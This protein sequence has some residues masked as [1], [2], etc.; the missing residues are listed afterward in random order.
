MMH[1]FQKSVLLLI[2]VAVLAACSS[3][4]EE[5]LLPISPTGEGHVVHLVGYA[6]GFET[7]AA[8][9][10]GTAAEAAVTRSA[11]S[12]YSAYVPGKVA[13]MG[14]YMLL[15]EDYAA[16][17][18]PTEQ[19]IK[20][21]GSKWHAYFSVE[22]N[23]TYTVYG[24]LPKGEGMSSSLSK[25]TANAATLTITGMKPITPDD[26]CVITGVK[27]TDNGL[28]EGYFSWY[29]SV[30][31]D[32][33]YI[34]MLLNHLYAS[35]RFSMKVDAEYAQLRT[36][37]L[38]SMT[39]QAD[40]ASVI[41]TVSLTHKGTGTETGTGTDVSYTGTAGSYEAEIFSDDEGTALS[42]QTET[43]INTCF[44]PTL[45][46]KLTLVTT[47]DV[48]DRH[49]N[50]IRKDR[51]VTNKLPNLDALRGYRVQ[52]NL[53]VNPTYLYVLSDPD[54]DAPTVVIEN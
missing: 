41:A 2:M 21:D 52:L 32:D 28:Q 43:F 33:Y 30:T 3:S 50:L 26:I 38:K 14:I 20:Y 12:G 9:A 46:D 4:S 1:I 6:P 49:G 48:Y 22:R 5:D 37:K 39:L 44:A 45:S 13:E 16:P 19:L 24:Y 36:I 40:V 34:Y 35:L 27:E 17:N 18:V 15:P 31:N 8:D 53:T 11:P 51:T 29:Q 25:S 23:K 7:P 10:P 54:L 47:Y 42:S